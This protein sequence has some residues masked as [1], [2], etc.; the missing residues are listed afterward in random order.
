MGKAT[1]ARGASLS[2]LEFIPEP[3]MDIWGNN[4]GI[5]GGPIPSLCMVVS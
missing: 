3:K 5:Q 1:K 4:E 2:V